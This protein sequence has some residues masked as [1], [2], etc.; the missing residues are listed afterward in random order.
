MRVSFWVPD[1]LYPHIAEGTKELSQ[2]SSI[3]AL[4]ILVTSQISHLLMLLNAS[5]CAQCTVRPNK[6]KHWSL[7][8][9]KVYCRAKKGEQMAHAH[10]PR[11]PH[12]FAGRSFIGKICDEGCRVY[13]FVLIG[14]WWGNKAL[15]PGLMLSLGAGRF[16]KKNSK[17]LC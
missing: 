7:Q 12:W 9:S 14:W 17:I 2:T 6:L 4:I 1:F 5:S 8:Q 13:D 3:R 16:L 15:A 11:T 10:K